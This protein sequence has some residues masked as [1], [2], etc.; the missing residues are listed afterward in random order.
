MRTPPFLHAKS[1]LDRAAL[2]VDGLRH[3]LAQPGL[4]RQ[5]SLLIQGAI[6]DLERSYE[7]TVD[8]Y[9][10]LLGGSGPETPGRWQTFLRFYDA[11]LEASRKARLD[12]LRS[13]MAEER[14][15]TGARWRGD[16]RTL[17]S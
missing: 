6:R 11:F 9:R 5:H 2:T 13:A 17:E 4:T 1:A 12:L 7:L 10:A 8:A 16:C 14:P 3:D 15:V